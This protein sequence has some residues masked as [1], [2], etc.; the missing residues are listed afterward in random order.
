MKQANSDIRRMVKENGFLLWQLADA[1][2]IYD[3]NLSRKLRKEL[4]TEQKAQIISAIEQMS[5]Q[6]KAINGK[7]NI[8]C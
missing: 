3:G 4:T 8:E 5:L 6:R 2:G 7:A 1:L